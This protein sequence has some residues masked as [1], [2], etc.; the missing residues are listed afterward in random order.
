MECFKCRRKD[1]EVKLIEAIS[2][3][4]VVKI[5]EECSVKENLPIIRKP[6]IEQIEE[7]QKKY[8]FKD[9]L[10]RM[11][12]K[13]NE[14]QKKVDNV[15][16]KISKPDDLKK[17]SKRQELVKKYELAKKRNIPINL[18]DNYNWHIVLN[19]RKRRISRK[20]LGEIIGESELALK[21]V[22]NKELPDNALRIINKIEQYFNINLTKKQ[23]K[24][25]KERIREAIDEKLRESKEKARWKKKKEVA[26]EEKPEQ[27]EKTKAT[28]RVLKIDINAAK[29]L[30]IA[31]LQKIKKEKERLEREEQEKIRE[32]ARIRYNE[33]LKGEN[34]DKQEKQENMKKQ[35]NSEDFLGEIEFEE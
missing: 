7:S 4:E 28:S 12:G 21:M 8:T 27:E 15:M 29:N 14:E 26:E 22:E 3:G 2:G 1:D 35:E 34:N 23:E 5:C 19:R 10:D 16:N 13:K 31:D 30:T 24:K 20:Q 17:M 11:K 25:E 9:R 33:V 6:T 32:K 18:I